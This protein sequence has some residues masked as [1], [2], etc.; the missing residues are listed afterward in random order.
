MTAYL[1]HLMIRNVI[2]LDLILF[3]KLILH[4]SCPRPEEHY[5]AVVAIAINI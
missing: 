1:D 3:K 4:S 2:E 5:T